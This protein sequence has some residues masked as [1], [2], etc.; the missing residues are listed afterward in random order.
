MSSREPNP[1]HGATP[2]VAGTAGLLAALA[3][4]VTTTSGPVTHLD[5]G[6]QGWVLAHQS[7]ALQQAASAVTVAG[8]ITAM[9]L[10]GLGAGAWFWRRSGWQAGALVLA[11]PW[12]AEWLCDAAKR[13]YARARPLGLGGGV[14]ATYAF[15]SAHAAVS[16][17][18]CGTIAYLCWR[19]GAAGRGTAAAAIVTSLLVGASRVV[20]NVHWASDVIGG[21]CGGVAVAMLALA[22][23][24]RTRHGRA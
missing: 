7:P 15:P 21:W 12:M 14:D 24:D 23:R 5:I 17:A 3:L 16:A 10:L 1:A 2:I 4:G 13:G 9:R 19:D 8:G 6:V 11:M 18:V 20:L 22:V